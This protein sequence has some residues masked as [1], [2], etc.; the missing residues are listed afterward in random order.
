[1][2]DHTFLTLKKR[3]LERSMEL[4]G[5]KEANSIDPLIDLLIDVF[6]YEKAKLHQEIKLSDTQLLHRLS[7]I[8]MSNKWSSPIPAHALML[9]F[10]NEDLYTVTPENHF[11][12]NTSS[13]GKENLSIF[14]TPL[15][16]S[17]V[18]HAQIKYKLFDT[19]LVYYNNKE[20]S[21]ATFF[22]TENRV[23]DNSLWLG[24]EI[25]DEKL[26]KLD[27]LSITILMQDLTLYPLLNTMSIYGEN[28]VNI[29]YQKNIFEPNELDETHYFDEIN[30]FYKDYFY[31]L[32]LVKNAHI[33]KSLTELF[34]FSKKEVDDLDYDQKLFWVK[35]KLPEIFDKEKIADFNVSLNTI[36]IVNRQRVYKQHNYKKNGRIVS[37][38]CEHKSY[39]LN[40]KSAQDDNGKYLKNILSDYENKK[41]GTYS[42][43]FGDIEKFDTRSAK[44]LMNKVMQS[45]REEG[46]AFAAMN[47]EKLETYLEELI[48]Q[49]DLLEQKA[50][51]KVKDIDMLESSFLLTYPYANGTNYEIE[52]WTTNADLANKFNEQSTFNQYATNEFDMK[53]TRL[54]TKT[55]GGKVRKGEREQID[56]LRYG[57]LTKERIV[58]TVDV[59]SY[60]NQQIGNYVSNIEIKPGAQISKEKK[61]GII[62]TTDVLITLNTLFLSKLDLNRLGV[63]FEN[64][65]TSK[66]ISNIPYKVVIQ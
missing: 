23:E 42:L 41:N 36:P 27:K 15:V 3:M 57:L 60:I 40:I 55:I 19:E 13:Y 9:I 49:L 46:N 38:P 43:Y 32:E 26:N 62:R 20:T 34:P 66:S 59:K 48:K 50:I 37:L 39:F 51:E 24:I 12:I 61:K 53:K 25:T 21:T 54:L 2:R 58:S 63:Y 35:I 22:D 4:W 28:R 29:N 45:I 5:I 6:A 16:E 44:V 18:H 10:P 7:R 56:S 64:E 1:M 11:Y 30:A 14:F 47:P 52:Y 31:S 17:T 8:L 33:K 65:L